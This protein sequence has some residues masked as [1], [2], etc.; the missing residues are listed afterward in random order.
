MTMIDPSNISDAFQKAIED[1]YWKM[2]KDTL[3]H[4]FEIKPEPEKLDFA[5]QYRA[6][7]SS[8]APIGERIL[9]YHADPIY[10]AADLAGF[11][12]TEEHLQRYDLIVRSKFAPEGASRR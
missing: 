4:V 1:R 6:L 3:Q 9:A 5:D 10:V 8:E 11:T 7:L 2:V 12:V